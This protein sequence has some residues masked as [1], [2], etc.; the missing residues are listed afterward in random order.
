MLSATVDDLRESRDRDRGVLAS[1]ENVTPPRGSEDHRRFDATRISLPLQM[2]IYIVS[3]TV[4]GTLGVWAANSGQNQ[5]IDAL[6][7]Q[8]SIVVEKLSSQQLI[9]EQESKLSEER[10]SNLRESVRK[11]EARIE[12]IQIQQATRDKEI[13]DSLVQLKTRRP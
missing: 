6:A 3:A 7:S 8:F 4:A 5:K 12:M 11:M 1:Y 9:K 10:L 13:N 2:V